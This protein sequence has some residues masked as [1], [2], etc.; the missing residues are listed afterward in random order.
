MKRLDF[1][2]VYVIER[3]YSDDE[4]RRDLHNMKNDGYNLITLWPIANPWL[5]DKPDEFI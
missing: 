4:I 5:T 1:G 2:A 3:D